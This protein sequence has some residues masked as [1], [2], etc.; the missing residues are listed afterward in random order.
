MS[1]RGYT[2]RDFF[3]PDY[4][5]EGL[6]LWIDHGVLPGSFLTAVLCN[7]LMDAFARAD[8]NNIR[9]LPAYCAYLYNQAPP[10]CFGS[11]ERVRAWIEFKRPEKAGD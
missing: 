10:H 6:D 11:K 3:I 8:E 7:D 1:A 2:Y 5:V 9:Q 4:M